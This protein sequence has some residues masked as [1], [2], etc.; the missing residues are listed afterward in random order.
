VEFNDGSQYRV[1]QNP[2]AQLQA[3]REMYA[4]RASS[5]RN[6]ALYVDSAFDYHRQVTA[7]RFKATLIYQ[8]VY[9][10]FSA[11][12][13]A[14]YFLNALGYGLQTQE[15]VCLDMESS[16]GFGAQNTS[17]FARDWLSMVEA[18]LRCRAWV[19]VPQA[20]S[21]ALSSAVTPERLIWAPRYSG[22][23]SRGPAPSWR[24]DAHQYTDRGFFPGC[25]L[26][27]DTSYTAMTTDQMLAR[28]NPSG[29]PEPAHGGP[30][31]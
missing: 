23:P 17:T 26:P 6:G 10:D 7:G 27:G 9:A 13:Q 3:G 24:Y 16:G 15:M 22:T 30:T 20:L 18:V 25:S 12:D 2:D 5:A 28:C 31:L 21:S 8:F 19:Y 4:Y 1:L 11:S 29:F 14:N